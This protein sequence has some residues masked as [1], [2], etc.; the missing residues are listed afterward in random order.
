[1]SIQFFAPRGADNQIVKLPSTLRRTVRWLPQIG[2]IFPDFNVETTEGPLN[3][4]KW[5][6]GHWVHL[7]SH[8]AANTPVCTTEIASIASYSAGWKAANVKNL[9]LTG[10]TIEEQTQWHADIAQLFNVEVDFPC[11]QDTGLRLS[12]LFGMM[13]EKEAEAWPIRKSFLIDPSMR[14]RMIFEYPVFIGRRTDEIMRVLHA[15]QMRDETGA[16]TPSDWEDGDIT[17]IPDDR[18]EAHV[19]RD[20]GANSTRLSPYLR[21][22]QPTG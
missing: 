8:P 16:A 9:A 5:A 4:W 22:V 1:M 17:I 12:K 15:L 2:D 3:F 20:F 19:W 6:E 11:A 21:V 18:P 14:L 7:F 10:S 13:H